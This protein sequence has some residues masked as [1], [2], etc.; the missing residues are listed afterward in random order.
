MLQLSEH[1]HLQRSLWV[2]W[3]VRLS[4]IWFLYPGL[5]A[6]I[7]FFHSFS[8]M[9]NTAFNFSPFIVLYIF[10][11]LDASTYCWRLIRYIELDAKISSSSLTFF[12][13]RYLKSTLISQDTMAAKRAFEAHCRNYGVTVKQYHTDNGRFADNTFINDCKAQGRTMTYC[14]VNAH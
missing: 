12:K 8:L 10:R 11:C 14:C 9:S 6:N 4:L 5:D 1:Q 2:S 13:F 7:Y 3:S